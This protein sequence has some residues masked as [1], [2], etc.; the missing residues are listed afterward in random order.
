MKLTSI[1]LP[2]YNRAEFIEDA[3]NSILSQQY[4]NWE[5]IIVDDGSSDN[6]SEIVSAFTHRIANNII[7]IKQ[8]N[9]GPAVAR[10]TGIAKASGDYIAFYDSDDIWLPHHLKNCISVLEKNPEVSWIYGACQ[11][12][13]KETNEIIQ[14]STFYT[15]E[16]PNLLFSLQSRITGNLHIIDDPNAAQM[17]IEHG[18]D[19]GL[20][21]SVLKREII[22]TIS[23]P[24]FRIGED[25][26]FIAMALKRGFTLAF[27][28]DI[29]VHYMV[30]GGNI[31][32]TNTKEVNIEKRVKV[33]QQLIECYEKTPEYIP[34]LNHAELATIKAK[35]AT[36]YF[37]VLGYALQ[38][39]NGLKKDAIK[40]YK[41]GMAYRPFY[42]RFWK[43]YLLSLLK[44]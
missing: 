40:S 39:Q 30:H 37:W 19:S 12:R 17:Q 33:I 10:N 20:Q 5:L 34:N 31:S 18:I 23:I 29:H 44:C 4:L 42:W 32:D 21:N 26:L 41:K 27:C 28:D 35:L 14:K 15:N 16:Q 13:I 8:E 25:R 6:T 43:T 2:T 36:E 11:R 38:W 1:I 3:F 9:Q 24:E 7:Y 22:D